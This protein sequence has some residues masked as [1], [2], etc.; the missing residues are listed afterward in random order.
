MCGLVQAGFGLVTHRGALG[1]GAQDTRDHT[2]PAPQFC[3]S[4]FVFVA[5]VGIVVGRLPQPLPP[6]NGGY[7][8]KSVLLSL[9]SEQQPQYGHSEPSL[10][11]THYVSW[12]LCFGS[13][14]SR[15]AIRFTSRQD[16]LVVLTQGGRGGNQ[17]EGASASLGVVRRPVSVSNRHPHTKKKREKKRKNKKK[18][19]RSKQTRR[20]Q[21]RE[22][23]SKQKQEPQ[24][25]GAGGRGGKQKKKKKGGNI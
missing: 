7:L 19:A 24:K 20:N 16:G 14:C 15:G 2:W 17:P 21:K 6:G 4:M 9:A 12:V 5:V 10:T 25:G 1:G 11:K 22:T 13:V 23:N 8:R 3:P 18:K